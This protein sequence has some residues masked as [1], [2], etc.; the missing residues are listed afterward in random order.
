MGNQKC[1]QG[2]ILTRM[3]GK[4]R[5]VALC[6]G[7][8]IKEFS[9]IPHTESLISGIMQAQKTNENPEYRATPWLKPEKIEQS[10]G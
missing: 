5:P 6:E 2:V 10:H 3:R 4:R 7:V 1:R 9:N 8:F